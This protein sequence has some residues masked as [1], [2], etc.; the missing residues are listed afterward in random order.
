MIRI[1]IDKSAA[2]P[3]EL[4]A[5]DAMEAVQSVIS[6]IG[7]TGRQDGIQLVVV[8]PLAAEVYAML[9]SVYPADQITP[10]MI[11]ATGPHNRA[12]A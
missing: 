5:L 8:E 10:E 12:L 7:A 2:T 1:T 11:R 6:H 9:R 3:E 4:A